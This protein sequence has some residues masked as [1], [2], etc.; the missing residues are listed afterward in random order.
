MKAKQE[1][2][3]L[4]YALIA[5]GSAEDFPL[6]GTDYCRLFS[7]TDFRAG[8]AD[9]VHDLATG[10]CACMYYSNILK[11]LKYFSNLSSVQS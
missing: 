6:I 11:K 3:I 10:I 9:A 7:M 5:N 4:M 1:S 2:G 8:L